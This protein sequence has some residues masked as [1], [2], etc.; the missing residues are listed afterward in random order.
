MLYSRVIGVMAGKYAM[1]FDLRKRQEALQTKIGNRLQSQ[2]FY[3]MI[4]RYNDL[5]IREKHIQAKV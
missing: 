4:M 3:K 5:M 2:F 1:K